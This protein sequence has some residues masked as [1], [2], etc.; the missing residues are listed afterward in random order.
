MMVGGIIGATRGGAA[1]APDGGGKFP[2]RCDY[3]TYVVALT[4]AKAR[5]PIEPVIIT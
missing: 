5:S 1:F 2:Q 3:G 4:G